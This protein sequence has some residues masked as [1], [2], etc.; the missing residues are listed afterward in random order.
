MADVIALGNTQSGSGL[1]GDWLAGSEGDVLNGLGGDD[2]LLGCAGD[3]TLD[4]GADNDTLQGG[5][6]NDT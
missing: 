4:G 6:G 3:D 1:Q 5:A 2:T